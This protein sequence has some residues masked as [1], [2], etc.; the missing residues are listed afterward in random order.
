MGKQKK[1][2]ERGIEKSGEGEIGIKT[3]TK[4]CKS[5]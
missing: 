4:E 5:I 2:K 3:D 1:K